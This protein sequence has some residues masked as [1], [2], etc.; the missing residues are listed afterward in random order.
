MPLRAS[1]VTCDPAPDTTGEERDGRPRHHRRA[2]PPRPYPVTTA[3]TIVTTS[4]HA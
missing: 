3:T 4:A 2:T 1:A